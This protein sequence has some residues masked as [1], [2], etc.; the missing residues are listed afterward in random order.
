MGVPSSHK[1]DIAIVV[2][3]L[4]G[5]QTK[6][7]PLP[8][9]GTRLVAGPPLVIGSSE[10]AEICLPSALGISDEHGRLYTE[11]GKLNYLDSFTQNGTRV[12]ID[13]RPVIIV[14]GEVSVELADLQGFQQPAPVSLTFPYV[15]GL[16]VHLTFE[17]KV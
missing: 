1:Y 6:E 8:D 9:L 5:L 10:H 4:E 7:T 17:R 13:G 2:R 3:T 11:K 16:E 15:E 12:Q 14:N